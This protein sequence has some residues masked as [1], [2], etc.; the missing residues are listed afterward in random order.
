[1]NYPYDS[2]AQQSQKNPYEF[3]DID[4][5][6]LDSY[7]ESRSEFNSFLQ[8]RAALNHT[9][10][11]P[12]SPQELRELTAFWT[13]KVATSI[14]LAKD[15]QRPL[16]DTEARHYTALIKKANIRT[17]KDSYKPDLKNFP[18][19]P[20]APIAAYTNLGIALGRDALTSD[21]LALSTALKVNDYLS[22]HREQ[23]NAADAALAHES[24][25]LEL[26]AVT[27]AVSKSIVPGVSPQ[28]PVRAPSRV[29]LPIG[30]YAQDTHRT[31][32]YIQLLSSA[33][34]APSHA[35]IILS[36]QEAMDEPVANHLFDLESS[37]TTILERE[38]IPYSLVQA[39]SLNEPHAVEALVARP[40]EYF[41]FAGRG[42]LTTPLESGKKLIHVHPG[43]LPEYRGSTTIF[44]SLLERGAATAT[45]FIMDRGI[46]RGQTLVERDFAPPWRGVDISRVYDPYI[47]AQV[48]IET[49]KQFDA[50]GSFSPIDQPPAGKEFYI[51]HPVARTI[52]KR[53]FL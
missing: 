40:E 7:H 24:V 1:M 36:P 49:F 21:A 14:R 6:I 35:T 51:I 47:R 17:L 2:P 5:S 19:A 18:G 43:K 52:V 33:G 50:R 26:R 13:D 45:S 10:V 37:I 42:L 34:Y 29:T 4:P 20:A 30:L 44:F 22:A 9:L 15:H 23:L 48:L 8:T 38:Q 39:N 27:Q 11:T 41:V 28:A 25:H 12:Y 46:D 32:A 3:H 53:N 31:K 16:S